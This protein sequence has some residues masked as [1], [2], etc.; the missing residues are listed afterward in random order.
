MV[1][2]FTHLHVHSHYSL[3]D[4]LP[5]IP[6]LISYVKKLGMD[7]I[8]LTDHGVLYGAIEFYKEAKKQGIKPIIGVEAYIAFN[9]MTQRRPGIDNKRY[10]LVLLVKNEVGYKN[11]VKLVTKSHLEGFYYKPRIDEKLLRKHSD[12]LIALSA[13]L[14]G[15][16]PQ[17]I[18]SNNI[19]KAEKQALSYQEIFGKENFYLEL[20]HHPNIEQQEKVNKAIIDIARKNNI[21]L[22]A[23]NDSHYLRPEDAKAQDILM[24]IN[25]GADLN[26]PERLSMLGVD[27][28][29]KKPEQMIADFK[30]TPDAI[31]NTEKIKEMCNLEFKLGS[32]ILP[33]F[34]LPNNQSSEDYLSEFCKKEIYKKYEKVTS[35]M[36]E[37]LNKELKIIIQRGYA[38]YFL[39]VA[40]FVNWAKKQ[41]IVVGPGRGSSAGS[42]TSYL[43]K[44]TDIDPLFFRVPFER[45]L[46]PERPK[47][48]DIDLD[49]A[50]TR[51]DEVIQY[52]KNK[53]GDDKVAQIITFGTMA[54]R[55]AVRDVGRAMN[56]SYSYCDKIAKAIPPGFKLDKALKQVKEFSEIYEQEEKARI[57]IDYA[58][59]LEGV[60]RHAST[61]ACGVVISKNRLDDIVPLQYSSQNDETIVTQYNMY[62][63]EDLGLLKMDFLGLKNLTILEKA[64]IL[65]EENHK[66]K[67]ELGSI[68]IDDQETFQILSK[69]NTTGIFQL[70]STGI[71]RNITNLKPTSIFDLMAML[72]L[73]RPGP[74]QIIPEF[75]KRKNNPKTITYLHPKLKEICKE[76][77]GLIVF[78]DDVLL[79]AVEIAGFS[80]GEA[81]KLRHAMSSKG[82]RPEMKAIHDK[83]ISGLIT[84]GGM[85]KENAEEMYR[86]IEPFGAYGFNKAHA[87]CYATISYQTA[88]LKAHYPV[89]FMAAV[90]A[91]EKNEVERTAFL[92]RECKAMDI[93]VLPPNINESEENFTVVGKDKIR[94]GLEAIKNV[95]HNIV[96]SIVQERKKN[97]RFSSITDFISRI[98]SK[99]LNKKSM[100]SLIKAG[101][102]DE[103]A[104]RQQ[105]L[106]NLEKLLEWIKDQRKNK[107]NGQK[108]LFNGPKFNDK[109]SLKKTKP[110]NK[111]EKLSW[112][113]ELLGLYISSHPLENFSQLLK[114]KSFPIANIV[115]HL[116]GT[117]KR[118]CVGGII[119][120]VKKVITRSGKPMLFVT[121]EDQTD[122]VEVVAFPRIVEQYAT[123]FQEEKIVFVMGRIDARGGSPKIICEEIEE[124]IEYT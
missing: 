76:S 11:L 109:V 35:E 49:F 105:L 71:R 9:G 124:I 89:E 83:F 37:R 5:K 44:I 2:K 77:Y 99:D 102:F 123:I 28:S 12:G 115:K 73:Y 82:H 90:L 100:E 52:V 93:E 57:L 21:P 120:N 8:A 39:I 88:Y 62:C 91:S 13:C 25:T 80:W 96:V 30:D 85:K 14:Q 110:A 16:I 7:S 113:K 79:V 107:S 29:I 26:D 74:M 50:D 119:S 36:L 65:I 72:A 20:Q 43:L 104:E 31:E 114:E 97:G 58:R 6:E 69:G 81:D 4:G 111:K 55:A 33:H 122:K 15:K 70:E 118:V 121:L 23:T 63:V 106:S 18:I 46:N 24:L 38:P 116:L 32:W 19:K 27:F 1:K 108:S 117:H 48:P 53:Y 51:R 66:V 64:L 60:A 61:H 67:I 10:H 56:Y 40:D 59:K 68:P 75:I 84:N 95:G 78:Q 86:F 41:G 45:F 103:L 112:E 47:A 101:A 87:A 22:V 34:P 42:I 94:F 54:A 98:K 17:L 92:I 3:L